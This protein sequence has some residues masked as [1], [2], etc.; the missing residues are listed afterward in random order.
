MVHAFAL[1]LE[2]AF[3]SGMPCNISVK[4]RHVILST[5]NW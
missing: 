3:F 2:A 4:L 1:S 5:K